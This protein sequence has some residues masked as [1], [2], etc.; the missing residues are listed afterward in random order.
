MFL[1]RMRNLGYIIIIIIIIIIIMSDAAFSFEGILLH[2]SVIIF[3]V[4]YTTGLPLGGPDS[5]I[6]RT[7]LPSCRPDVLGICNI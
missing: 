6:I 1:L 7:T 4:T 5:R 2:H 3:C